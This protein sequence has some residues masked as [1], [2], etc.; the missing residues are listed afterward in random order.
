MVS[1]TRLSAQATT[2]VIL[3]LAE[4]PA[5]WRYGSEL[6]QQPSAA[7]STP[8][9]SHPGRPR[10]AAWSTVPPAGAGMMPAATNSGT[11]S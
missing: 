3:A 4:Q 9:S 8:G 7:A 1:F 2:V 11:W 5:T 6:C 10:W